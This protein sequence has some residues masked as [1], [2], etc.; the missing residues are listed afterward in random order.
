MSA[1]TDKDM[2]IGFCFVNIYELYKKSKNTPKDENGK[3]LN[4][5]DLLPK[6]LPIIAF[7]RYVRNDTV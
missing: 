7:R 4:E 5:D 1:E 2:G 3:V 6:D